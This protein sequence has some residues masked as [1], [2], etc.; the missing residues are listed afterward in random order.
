V[1][2]SLNNKI[3][4]GVKDDLALRVKEIFPLFTY[5]LLGTGYIIP[6]GNPQPYLGSRLM[7]M[8]T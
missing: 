1:Y 8:Y 4:C 3:S 5:Q 6:S 2:Q 7:K